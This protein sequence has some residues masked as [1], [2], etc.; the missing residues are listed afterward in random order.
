MNNLVK[1][2]NCWDKNRILWPFIEKQIPQIFKFI[3]PIL[4]TCTIVH[5]TQIHH[6]MNETMEHKLH[7]IRQV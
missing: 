1:E 5:M 3:T 6:Y 4:N 2:T 7:R